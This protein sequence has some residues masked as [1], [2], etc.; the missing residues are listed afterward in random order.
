M[1]GGFESVVIPLPP[2][3][4]GGHSSVSEASFVIDKYSDFPDE[5]SLASL[6]GPRVILEEI[7]IENIFTDNLPTQKWMLSGE[8]EEWNRFILK[9]FFDDLQ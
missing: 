9:Q 8:E 5:I 1:P 7:K 2:N 3:S 4:G 6:G